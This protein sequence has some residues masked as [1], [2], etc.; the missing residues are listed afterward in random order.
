MRIDKHSTC[1]K[2]TGLCRCAGKTVKAQAIQTSLVDG[3]FKGEK[4]A[5]RRKEN[6]GQTW[7]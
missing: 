5:S 1:P 4:I 3:A 6:A 2:L 7:E